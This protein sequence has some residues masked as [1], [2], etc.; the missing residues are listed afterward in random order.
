[1]AEI[2]TLALGP[3]ENYI[4]LIVDRPSGKVAVV[5]PA[6][7]VE[8]ILARVEA[9]GWHVEWILLTHGHRDHVN[10]V[11]ALQAATGAAVYVR[12]Q[13]VDH[14]Q[15]QE[16]DWST[17][18]GGKQWPL[19]ESTIEAIPTPGHTP[20]GT[21]YHVGDHLVTGDTLFVYGCGRCDLE[22]G[23]PRQMYHSLQRLLDLPAHTRIYPGHSYSLQPT[24]TLAEERAGNPFLHC[25]DEEA[26]VEYRMVRHDQE[27]ESPYGPVPREGG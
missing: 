26:F 12:Q 8:K 19:G 3:M 6:W 16:R 27:R 23:D 14:F 1:M 25:E 9:E 4:H 11:E 18:E 20:G 13:E 2:E 5:D 7:E 24:S 17:F 22:G 21:C 10:G 15:F